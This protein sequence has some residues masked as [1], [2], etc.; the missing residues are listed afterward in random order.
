MYTTL[1]IKYPLFLL[2][3]NETLNKF[4]KNTHIS[5]CMKI[6]PVGGELFHAVRQT[7][8][9]KLITAFRN[10]VNVPEGML[11]MP[12]RHTVRPQV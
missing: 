5:N 9:F 8:R 2:L 4:L 10:F 1:H 7:D 11:P 3:F 12:P 6:H